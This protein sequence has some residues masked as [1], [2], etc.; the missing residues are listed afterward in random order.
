[1][2][3]INHSIILPL[4]AGPTCSNSNDNETK[5]AQGRAALQERAILQDLI[6]ASAENNIQKLDQVLTRVRSGDADLDNTVIL[7]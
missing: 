1:M 4:L 5:E 6:H 7:R 2:I 3:L